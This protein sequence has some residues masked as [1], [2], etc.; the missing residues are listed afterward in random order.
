M[1]ETEVKD[2]NSE[3]KKADKSKKKSRWQDFKSEYRKI[4]WP[5]PKTAAKETGEVIVV[6]TLLAILIAGIDLVIKFGFDRIL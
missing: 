5:T 3:S 1:D 6:T 4:V 2:T